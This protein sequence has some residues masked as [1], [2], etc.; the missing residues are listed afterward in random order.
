[1]LIYI[2]SYPRSGSSLIQQIVDNFFEKHNQ[3]RLQQK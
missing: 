3:A 2:S 1:M